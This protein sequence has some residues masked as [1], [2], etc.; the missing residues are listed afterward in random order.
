MAKGIKRNSGSQRTYSASARNMSEYFSSR[1]SK[2]DNGISIKRDTISFKYDT[3]LGKK[4]TVTMSKLALVDIA[5]K[6]LKDI[7]VVDY[8]G[9]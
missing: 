2:R 8:G 5:N 1:Q 9:I 6:A 4:R 7:P 3:G